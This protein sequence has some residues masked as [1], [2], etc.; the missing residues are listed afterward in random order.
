MIE[1][2]VTILFIFY[3]VLSLIG[4]WGLFK[5]INIGRK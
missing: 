1:L 2:I 5:L 4:L 3:W